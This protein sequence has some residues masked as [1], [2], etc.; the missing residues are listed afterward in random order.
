ME[1]GRR[2]GSWHPLNPHPEPGRVTPGNLAMLPEKHAHIVTEAHDE[3]AGQRSPAAQLAILARLAN[4]AYQRG[5][6]D[7]IM[8][9]YT[10]EDAAAMLGLNTE[11]VRKLAVKLHVGWRPN[12]RVTLFNSADIEA[13]RNRPRATPGRK[14]RTTQ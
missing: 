5:R 7:A 1:S 11:V 10:P 12:P 3:L 14:P 4:E 13:I 8:D 9:L 6:H 2:L